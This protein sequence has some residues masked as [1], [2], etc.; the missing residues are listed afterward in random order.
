MLL[1]ADRMV[2][3]KR[4]QKFIEQ[5]G[6]ANDGHHGVPVTALGG[7]E[8]VAGIQGQADVSLNSSSP[9]LKRTSQESTTQTGSSANARR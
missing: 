5:C 2:Y 9:L 6:A 3:K 1:A 4:C 8:G 7:A